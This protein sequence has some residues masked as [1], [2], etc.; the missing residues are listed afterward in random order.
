MAHWEMVRQAMRYKHTLLISLLAALSILLFSQWRGSHSPLEGPASASSD[1]ATTISSVDGG[2]TGEGD[3][4]QAI[5]RPLQ[6]E[7]RIIPLTGKIDVGNR[8][9]STVML[10]VQTSAGETKRC[11]GVVIGREL[12]L[13]AGHCVCFGRR[14]ATADEEGFILDA[15]G[16]ASIATVGTALY[17]AQG[18][19]ADSAGARRDVYTGVVRVHPDF[20]IILDKQMRLISSVADLAVVRLRKPLAEDLHAVELADTPVQTNEAVVIVGYG[21]DEIAN[22]YDE[23][24]RFSMNRV[25]QFSQSNREVVLVE[26]P[27]QHH[28]RADSGGP[29][30]REGPDSVVLVGISTRSLGTGST[31]LSTHGYRGWIED[32]IQL[33]R[34]AENPT[35]DQHP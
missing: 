4:P 18:D 9:L 20:K 6:F 35:P 10:V 21:Y 5:W 2:S 3:A 15:S 13:T 28:Y 26:Q 30:L 24:R 11:S 1:A 31:F 34:K 8:Y 7:N 27:G 12:V 16:C 23:D 33:Q 17:I 22:V 19:G 29:C 25:L 32:E 14:L